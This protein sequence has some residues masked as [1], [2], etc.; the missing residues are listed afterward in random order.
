MEGGVRVRIW[1]A[2]GLALLSALI[3]CL[4]GFLNQARFVVI[5]YRM[6]ISLLLFGGIGYIVAYLYEIKWKSGVAGLGHNAAADLDA[7]SVEKAAQE[8]LAQDPERTAK[9][10]AKQ[11]EAEKKE[12]APFTSDTMTHVSPPGE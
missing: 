10:G 6:L 9:T 4:T 1:V 11:N 12:F 8:D 7:A 2:G 3:T 5:L